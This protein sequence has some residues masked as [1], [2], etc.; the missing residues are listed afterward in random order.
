M[1]VPLKS[2]IL[3]DLPFETLQLLG[4]PTSQRS[5]GGRPSRLGRA[6]TLHGACNGSL[7]AAGGE[8][9]DLPIF[10]LEFWPWIS[11][12]FFVYFN[13]LTLKLTNEKSGN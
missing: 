11:H 10:S 6:E 12:P 13:M 2:S 5:G 9:W 7:A 3:S 4:S 8:P 1:L